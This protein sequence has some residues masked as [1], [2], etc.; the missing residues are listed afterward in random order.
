MKI[1]R[2]LLIIN[3]YTKSLSTIVCTNGKNKKYSIFIL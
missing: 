1:L 2:V 3:A